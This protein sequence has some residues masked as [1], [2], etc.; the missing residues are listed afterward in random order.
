MSKTH[1]LNAVE[2]SLR[3]LT[4]YNVKDGWFLA[5]ELAPYISHKVGEPVSSQTVARYLMT[6]KKRGT[7]EDKIYQQAQQLHKWRLAQ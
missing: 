1:L 2:Q 7:V 3:E 6:L 5:R 4:P